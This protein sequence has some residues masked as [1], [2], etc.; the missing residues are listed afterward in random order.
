MAGRCTLQ[1]HPVFKWQWLGIYAN[2][3]VKPYG[4]VGRLNGDEAWET[5]KEHTKMSMFYFIT[6]HTLFMCI[7]QPKSLSCLVDLT[8]V[9]TQFVL[10]A[11]KVKKANENYLNV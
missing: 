10:W 6:C 9:N 3:I 7:M 8:K 2:C 1:K 11:S 5:S 4:I